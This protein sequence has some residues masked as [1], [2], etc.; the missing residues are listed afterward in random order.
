MDDVVIAFAGLYEKIRRGQNAGR[1]IEILTP[2]ELLV[3]LLV[4]NL[5]NGIHNFPMGIAGKKTV[6]DV[7]NEWFVICPQQIDEEDTPDDAR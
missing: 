6:I 5:M 7:C 3:L 4:H 2:D 1:P